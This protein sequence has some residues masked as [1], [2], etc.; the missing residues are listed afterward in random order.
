MILDEREEEC[1]ERPDRYVCRGCKEVFPGRMVKLHIT[2][3]ED[4]NR[5]GYFYCA[6]CLALLLRCI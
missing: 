2:Y 6:S 1:M 4:R 3:T 5:I